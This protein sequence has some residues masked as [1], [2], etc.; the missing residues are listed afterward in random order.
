[1]VSL[2][3]IAPGEVVQNERGQ[4]LR[5]V[6]RVDELVKNC[7]WVVQGH[8]EIFDQGQVGA[9]RGELRPDMVQA[10]EAASD[11][12]L[13]MDLETTGLGGS[14]LFLIGLMHFNRETFLVEQL[15]ARDY[16]EEP[17]VLQY[18]H[19]LSRRFRMLVTFNG[20]S[21]DVPQ[22][23]DRSFATGTRFE[24]QGLGHVD[25]LHEA[26]RRWRDR[27]PNCK[28]QTLETL[29]CRRRRVGDIPGDQIPQA[30]HDF[31]RS[32]NAHQMKDILH[33][34]ALD[35]ITM[36]ELLVTML[37]GRRV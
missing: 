8:A 27:F 35:L 32:G 3:E 15:L 11:Q 29:I 6:R 34:N 10:L 9:D 31:V 12:F 30:Y 33:H 20:K 25:L 23:T 37:Q 28:L 7:Q 18:Y 13:F 14:P 21:F 19:E 24:D 4:F 22:V 16:S 5:I 1:M 2:S 26:R 17:A 36:A